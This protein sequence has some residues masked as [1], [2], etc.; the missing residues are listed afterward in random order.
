MLDNEY[1]NSEYGFTMTMPDYWINRTVIIQSDVYDD[2][3]DS[4]NAIDH[5]IFY[6]KYLYDNGDLSS[7]FL[8]WLEIYDV[9]NFDE[10]VLQANPSAYVLLKSDKYVIIAV[11]RTGAGIIDNE[12]GAEQWKE[13]DSGIDD[14][15]ASFS[16][17]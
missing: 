3:V 8:F 2:N 1:V 17:T 7:A 9:E 4:T 12:I 15:F 6:N 10:S 16:I 13:M 14:V 11:K 5:I